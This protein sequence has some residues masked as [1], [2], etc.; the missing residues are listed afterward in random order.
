MSIEVRPYQLGTIIG[1]YETGNRITCLKAFVM[2]PAREDDEFQ[3]TDDN[4]VGV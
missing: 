1:S 2:L 3:D 4:F